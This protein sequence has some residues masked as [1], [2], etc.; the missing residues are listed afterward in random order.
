MAKGQRDPVREQLWRERMAAW[1]ASGLSI[2]A[3]CLR[4]GL[5]ETSFHY[6]RRELRAREEATAAS[7]R[8]RGSSPRPR[9]VPVV[10]AAPV[11]VRCPTGHVVTLA[12]A[13]RAALGELFAALAEGTPC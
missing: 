3:F 6:W 4:H 11:E 13:D 7:P 10:L 1:R 9:F 2:R 5:T 12:N 8:A